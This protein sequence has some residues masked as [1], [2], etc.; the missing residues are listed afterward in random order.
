MRQFIYLFVLVVLF[1]AVCGKEDKKEKYNVFKEQGSML[2]SGTSSVESRYLRLLEKDPKNLA[3]LIK[4]GNYYFDSGQSEKAIEMYHRALELN[5]GDANVRTD[6]GVMYR[7]LGKFEKAIE[8][9]R[10][11]SKS[12]PRHVQ[13]RYNLGIVYYHDKKNMEKA[14]D[15]WEEVLKINP[16]YPKAADLRKFINEVREGGKSTGFPSHMQKGDGWIQ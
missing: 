12:N 10:K 2:G 4:L 5:P 1:F 7:R 14:A 11:A 16:S 6:M 13:S 15:A 8:A 3:A 9:F